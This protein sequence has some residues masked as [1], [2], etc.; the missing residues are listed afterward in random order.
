M[1]LKQNSKT[2]KI[3]LLVLV[4]V[5][6]M[7]ISTANS[8]CVPAGSDCTTTD[9]CS[10]YCNGKTLYTPTSPTVS[11]SGQCDDLEN[12]EPITCDT[13]Q[14]S[15]TTCSNACYDG[16]CVGC[17]TANDCPQYDCQISSCSD[18]HKC[19]YTPDPACGL[20]ADAG[21]DRTVCKD[22]I[23]TFYGG[24]SYSKDS[25]YPITDYH[26][27]FSDD[28]S[29]SHEVVVSHN[30]TSLPNNLPHTYNA[31]LTVSNG[32][33]YS[34]SDVA[35][36]NVIPEP[37]S[38]DACD[39]QMDLS[40]GVACG[41][42][43]IAMSINGI[44][45]CADNTEISFVLRDKDNTH[46]DV[47][48]TTTITNGYA[49]C[50]VKA[51]ENTG[52]YYIYAN[53]SHGDLPVVSSLTIN[54]RPTSTTQLY[55][56]NGEP[57]EDVNCTNKNPLRMW[58]DVKL[59]SLPLHFS[60]GQFSTNNQIFKSSSIG[61][62]QDTY[63]NFT[64]GVNCYGGTASGGPACNCPYCNDP[65]YYCNATAN[66]ENENL[67][68]WLWTSDPGNDF[69]YYACDEDK[70]VLEGVC[71]HNQT[72]YSQSCSDSHCA[73]DT[74]IVNRTTYGW[75]YS[76]NM[77]NFVSSNDEFI[78][79][80]VG[81]NQSPVG[82]ET[83]KFTGGCSGDS[84][85]YTEVPICGDGVCDVESGERCW[86]CPQDC[87][88][89]ANG[90][91]SDFIGHCSNT[92]SSYCSRCPTTDPTFSDPRGCVIR[93]KERG[94]NASCPLMCAD[95]LKATDSYYG[96]GDTPHDRVKLHEHKLDHYVCCGPDEE[97][98]VLRNRCEARRGIVVDSI[99]I[100]YK[101][102]NSL[103]N[104]WC[105]GQS[106][107]G[108]TD[109]G[110]ANITFNLHNYNEYEP[111]T[112][113]FTTD[114]GVGLGP[115]AFLYD[116]DFLKLNYHGKFFKTYSQTITLGPGIQKP[117]SLLW[118]CVVTDKEDCYTTLPFPS[119]KSEKSTPY[120]IY[121]ITPSEKTKT[122]GGY[123]SSIEGLYQDEEYCSTDKELLIDQGGKTCTYDKD[124]T[125]DYS[126]SDPFDAL[127][128]GAELPNCAST[129]I[130][131]YVA[132]CNPFDDCSCN[133]V[134]WC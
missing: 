48:C 90:Q 15:T 35:R 29:D 54:E 126:N 104:E 22:H 49:A 114:L 41:G 70:N 91:R 66:E 109:F 46:E 107:S 14:Y 79:M 110:Y 116:I 124:I 115:D 33:P 13:C 3:L 105:C 65:S 99:D 53:T 58:Q 75:S 103:N 123:T 111:E 113:T 20:V 62:G 80:F 55:G 60:F 56:P 51:P 122:I 73:Y 30:Y 83:E 61:C 127:C 64:Y 67:T 1:K 12:C 121:Y 98:N 131:L 96:E 118:Q 133:L 43:V 130:P 44:K 31:E 27:V 38:C 78:P 125:I 68:R 39:A 63:G 57:L 47:L 82:G 97:W 93:F 45:N 2:W 101:H 42:D 106:L 25:N 23:V 59:V 120:I 89:N 132:D 17:N 69:K 4:A 21:P 19:G 6:L 128:G 34:A 74:H 129:P 11:C 36:I 37:T 134:N 119:G 24:N 87:G 95:G 5:T 32:V 76:Y 52:R 18:D 16:Q 81:Y 28:N 112:F 7:Y 8:R 88:E 26:W 86:N 108:K 102:V 100:N 92:D 117:V 40:K 71:Y 50:V 72:N 94:E 77:V 85:C 9:T 84:N 10:S